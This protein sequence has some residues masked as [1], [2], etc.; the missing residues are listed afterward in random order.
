MT[1]RLCS[2]NNSDRMATLVHSSLVGK[3]KEDYTVQ[4][5]VSVLVDLHLYCHFHWCVTSFTCHSECIVPMYSTGTSEL[6]CI[7]LISMFL[8]CQWWHC[9]KECS[10][11]I[12]SESLNS[13]FQA[14]LSCPSLIFSQ[15]QLWEM[16]P[17]ILRKSRTPCKSQFLWILIAC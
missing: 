9:L 2:T 13:S 7:Q 12:P 5:I 11:L 3:R 4:G 17:K 10:A 6:Y 15:F 8:P 14:G 1:L 16:C